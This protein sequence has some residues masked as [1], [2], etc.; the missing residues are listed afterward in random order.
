MRVC[1]SLQLYFIDFNSRIQWNTTKRKQANVPPANVSLTVKILIEKYDGKTYVTWS[2]KVFKFY[3]NLLRYLQLIDFDNDVT[4]LFW[5]FCSPSCVL[6]HLSSQKK[7][8]VC[9]CTRAC[10]GEWVDKC[11]VLFTHTFLHP[12]HDGYLFHLFVH[13]VQYTVYKLS[14]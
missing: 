2:R 5:C 11:H 6:L 7:M 14:E 13:I 4:E 8:Y 12:C 9:L 10:D 3:W 1:I